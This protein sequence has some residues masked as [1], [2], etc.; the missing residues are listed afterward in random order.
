MISSTSSVFFSFDIKLAR[1]LYSF[2]QPNDVF[3]GDR[4]FCAYADL[5]SITKLGCD[6]IFRKHQSRTTTIRKGKI[7]GD[8]DKLVT[9]YKPKICPKGLSKDEFLALPQTITVREIT[10]TLLLL[11]FVQKELA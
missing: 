5:V 8:C 11:V 6:V 2:L 9:W 3:L 4:A 7:V 1:K 10:I